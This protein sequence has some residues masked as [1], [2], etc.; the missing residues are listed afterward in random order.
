MYLCRLDFPWSL[1]PVADVLRGAPYPIGPITQSPAGPGMAADS[2][3]LKSSRGACKVASSAGWTSSACQR[4][5]PLLSMTST[6]SPATLLDDGLQRRL[7][8]HRRGR[9]LQVPGD[10]GALGAQGVEL[11]LIHGEAVS[12][13]RSPGASANRRG[14][15]RPPGQ[16]PAAASGAMSRR[17]CAA[18]S[19]LVQGLLRMP[20]GPLDQLQQLPVSKHLEGRPVG[21]PGAHVA[22]APDLPQ[23]GQLPMSQPGPLP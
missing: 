2:V 13:P 23:I 14:S 10:P 1:A 9:D 6:E 17:S 19:A 15:G 3:L 12:R 18:A 21:P 11:R 16:S 4:N 8:G 20:L 7:G 22:P 5:S